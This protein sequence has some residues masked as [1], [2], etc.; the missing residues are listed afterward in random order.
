MF[1]QT[2]ETSATPHITITEC[3]GN[4]TVRGSEDRR[5]ALRVQ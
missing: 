4:L 3:L 1:K 5:F 2:F